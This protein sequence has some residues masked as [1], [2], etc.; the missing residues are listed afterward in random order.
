MKGRQKLFWDKVA[1]FYDTFENLYN[2]KVNRKLVSNVSEL[3]ET[4]DMV[5]ECACGTGMISKGI[6]LKCK[7]LVA[8]DFSDGMLVQ[9]KKNCSDLSN[10]KI[11]KADIMNLNYGN[12]FFDKVVAGNVIHLL[13]EP[14][15]ALEELLRVC[16]TGGMVIIPTYINKEN[17]GKSSFFI[18]CFEKFGADFKKQFDFESYKQFFE[19]NGLED[20]SYKII[21]GKM[22]CAIAI[23][24]KK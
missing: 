8:T 11:E 10:V 6:A 18:R 9:A 5:L 19:K 3:I 15:K 23:I 17:S 20:V 4:N 13:D 7:E 24:I 12:E 2:G 14:Y 16:K 21:T 1:K 22:P